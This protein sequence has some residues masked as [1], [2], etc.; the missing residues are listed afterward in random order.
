MCWRQLIAADRL[1]RRIRDELLASEYCLGDHRCGALVSSLGEIVAVVVIGP[2]CGV[3]S[4][5]AKRPMTRKEER[6]RVLHS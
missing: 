1:H 5:I 2:T 4:E 6:T 3:G